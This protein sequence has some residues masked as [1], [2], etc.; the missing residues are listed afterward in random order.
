MANYRIPG[1]TK[2]IDRLWTVDNGTLARYPTAI[3]GLICAES[4]QYPSKSYSETISP[5][6]Q[7]NA[8][9]LGFLFNQCLAPQTG[10]EENDYKQAANKLNVEIAAIKAVAEVES[11]GSAFDKHGRPRILYERHYFSRLTAGKYNTSHPNISNKS[12]G[13]YGKFSE[14]YTK[15]ESAFKLDPD[16]ALRSASWGRFQIMGNNFKA[17][18]FAAVG[19][20][21]LKLT[22]SE[23]E[24]LKSFSTFVENDKKMLSA[25]QNKD[26][27][28]FAKA[29]NGPGYKKNSYDTK[30][31]S[32]FE[33]FSSSTSE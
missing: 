18:G 32:A 1:I 7:T 13:G 21:V 11:A 24:H 23:S 27:P 10:L 6:K 30:L 12:S 26:W 33:R 16:A 22:K 20:F 4:L 15:L 8:L 3:P 25:L 9:K 19:D 31:K 14:Q 5:I 28:A 2:S 29:Y 17:A